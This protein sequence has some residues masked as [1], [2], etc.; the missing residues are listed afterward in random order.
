MNRSTRRL[1]GRNAA[2]RRAVECTG[3][4]QWSIHGGHPNRSIGRSLSAEHSTAVPNRLTWAILP[5][6]LFGRVS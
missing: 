3:L 6:N 2:S 4:L 1:D 5:R